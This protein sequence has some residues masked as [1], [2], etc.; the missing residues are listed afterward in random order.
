MSRFLLDDRSNHTDALYHAGFFRSIDLTAPRFDFFSMVN[1]TSA[2]FAA[3]AGLSALAL[4]IKYAKD[5]F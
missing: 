1:T 2:S 5:G 4:R 3:S